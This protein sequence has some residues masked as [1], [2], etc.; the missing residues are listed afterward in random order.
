[1]NR[2]V[3]TSRR[4]AIAVSLLGSWCMAQTGAAQVFTTIINVPPD[5]ASASIGSDTQLNLFDNG[6]IGDLFDAGARDGTSTNV[7]VNISGGTVGPSF[8]ANSNSQVNITGGIFQDGFF[9]NT[10][11]NVS[12]SGGR[13]GSF[14]SISGSTVTIIG[15]EFIS[16][17]VPVAGLNVPGDSVFFRNGSLHLT[18]TLTD[19][20]VVLFSAG[21]GD[22]FSTQTAKLT[23]AA[24]PAA[25]P[26]VINSPADPTP[27][28]LRAGQTL[29][30]AA[31]ANLGD[32]FAA[33]GATLNIDGGTVGRGLEIENTSVTMTGGSVGSDFRVFA[34]SNVHISGGSIGNSFTPRS[35]SHV[36]IDGG[37]IGDNAAAQSSSRMTINGGVIGGNFDVFSGSTVN[38]NGGSIGDFFDAN[39]SSTV[40]I[41]G[42]VLGNSIDI[43]DGATVNIKGGR[44]GQDFDA[45]GGSFVIFTGGEFLMDGQPI[46]GLSGPG[47]R[48]AVPGLSTLTGTLEDG[49]AFVFSSLAEDDFD[50]G[51]V[52]LQLGTVP[53]ITPGT[54]GS[55]GSPVPNGVRAGERLVLSAGA[56]VGDHFAAVGGELHIIGGTAGFGLE[57]VDTQMA[58]SSGSV[59]D[60]LKIYA[61]STVDISGGTVGIQAKAFVG[62]TVNIFGEGSVGDL[63]GAL[64]GSTV[65]IFG[66]SVGENFVAFS[67]STVNIS[68]GD[69][70]SSFR[71]FVGS[72]INILGQTF[73]KTDPDS[74]GDLI[75]LTAGLTPGVPILITSRV[76]QLTGTLTDGSAFNFNIGSF[77]NSQATLTIALLPLAG[78]LDFDG[79]V[80][81]ADLNLIL[82]QWNQNVTPGDLLLGDPTGDGFV[83]IEDLGV[84]LGN[85]NAGT[86][87]VAGASTNIPE[88]GT[89]GIFGLLGLASVVT[90]RYGLG[91]GAVRA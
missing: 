31:G 5:V 45:F 70:S 33:V 43:Q 61:G 16:G 19:G 4:F 81:I 49:S 2:Y 90:G 79:F 11:S 34:G 21:A 88:P 60:G 39:R 46:A 63:F 65:N 91:N 64:T 26:S 54:I 6:A 62:S 24:I 8:F 67:D 29:N 77:F 82:S 17:G 25:G 10:G 48:V 30:L 89:L 23:L 35:G 55:P 12:I 72:E 41:N 32:N 84:V 80:G 14:I 3:N 75:D 51:T 56:D 57:V 71:A 68:G 59:G 42:G 9:A 18:G 73:F 28:G 47:D 27:P 74:P 36:T 37:V 76:G 13:V 38:I 85:W 52:F 15:D 7:E 20:S 86:P 53:A 87:P 58:I 66:G 44:F 78:D 22:F 83:G 40:N 69:V 1:M 50:P